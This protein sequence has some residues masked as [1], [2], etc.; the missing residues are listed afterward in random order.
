MK[1]TYKKIFSHYSVCFCFGLLFWVALL[2]FI[3]NESIKANGQDLILILPMIFFALVT[4]P[5]AWMVSCILWM[6]ATS[7][8]MG[9]NDFD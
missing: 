3:L 8:G 5:F 6:L 1:K 9:M 4:A 2:M 7:E